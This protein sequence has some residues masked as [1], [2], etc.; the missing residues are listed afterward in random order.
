MGAIGPWHVGVRS[1]VPG[2]AAPPGALGRGPAA[3]SGQRFPRPEPPP[4]PSPGVIAPSSR[5]KRAG[6]K[7][8]FGLS[9]P[10]CLEHP[11]APAPQRVEEF[12]ERPPKPP[13]KKSFSKKRARERRERKKE[14]KMLTN[15]QKT[16]FGNAS[17]LPA[18]LSRS[19][20]VPSPRQLRAT[21]SELPR[22]GE[23]PPAAPSPPAPPAPLPLLYY[24][25]TRVFPSWPGKPQPSVKY[26][27]KTLRSEAWKCVS[28]RLRG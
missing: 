4:A 17:R 1:P 28:Q 23:N 26:V 7:R 16:T 11:P 15:E 22:T 27:F 20:R 3:R 2:P 18:L 13:Q 12:S 6:E 25:Y 21:G 19:R 24:F 10:H 14:Q 5:A 8:D 9:V